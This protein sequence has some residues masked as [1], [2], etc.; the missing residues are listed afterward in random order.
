MIPQKITFASVV[1][2]IAIASI[3]MVVGLSQTQPTTA[4]SKPLGNNVY[5]FAEGVYPQVTF[6]FR[7]ATVTYDF[8]GYT[9][10]TGLF[11]NR[12]NGVLRVS[13]PEFK[14]ERIVGDT[15]Y[16]HRAVDQSWQYNGR[17]TAIEYPYRLFDITVEF[18][19]GGQS[20]RT[21]EYGDCSIKDYQIRTEFDKE[22]GY[23][24]GGKTGFAVLETYTIV[25]N[26]YNPVATTYDAM[27]E[28]KQNRKPYE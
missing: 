1:M 28:E 18:M 21:L 8:Q 3:A 6:E 7:E 15:P 12:N 20:I 13:Q 16:L 26:G 14:L 5:V 10:V 9:Q 4:Q 25:C 2:A 11:D 27:I 17:A 24:T 23:T 22:E 19:Q